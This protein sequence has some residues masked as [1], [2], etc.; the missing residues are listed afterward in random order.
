[1]HRPDGNLQ[2]VGRLGEGEAQ[3]VPEH[4]NGSM[5]GRQPLEAPVE[6]ILNRPLQA[7]AASYS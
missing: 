4:D 3:V 5:V 2:G 7:A 6:L 1:L